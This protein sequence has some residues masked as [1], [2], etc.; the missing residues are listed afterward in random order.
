MDVPILSQLASEW[1]NM[2]PEKAVDMCRPA[3]QTTK[4]RLVAQTQ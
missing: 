1:R 2:G 4:L 3:T